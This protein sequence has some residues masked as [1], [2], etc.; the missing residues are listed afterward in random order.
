MFSRYLILKSSGLLVQRL[1]QL[2]GFERVA[3]AWLIRPKPAWLWLFIL[4]FLIT[5]RLVDFFNG[6][7]RLGWDWLVIGFFKGLRSVLLIIGLYNIV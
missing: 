1:Y 7:L 5:Q 2:I 4:F 3:C 6:F